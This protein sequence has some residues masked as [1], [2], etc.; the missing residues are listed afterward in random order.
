MD[1]SVKVTRKA[2][3]KLAALFSVRKE[4][5]PHLRKWE[6]RLLPD[7]YDHN[8]FEYTGQPTAEEF[9]RALAYQ[10]ENNCGFIKLEGN[11]PLQDSFG[12]EAGV[13]LTMVLKGDSSRWRRNR[14]AVFGTP[15]LAELEEL[16][17]KHFGSLYGEDFT[18]RNAR[19]LYEKLDYHGAYLGE[20]LAGACYSF[21]ADNTVCVDGLIV[22]ES[23]RHQY[24]ATSLLAHIAE[25]AGSLLFLHADADDTPKD[26]YAKMG[27][28]VTDRLYEYSCTDLQKLLRETAQA[29]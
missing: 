22:D 10:R 27:F 18:R 12:L 24:I 4:F 28:A 8:C 13:T 3:E 7:K 14:E 29:R 23:C 15:S 5:S 26:M 20:K 1:D 2:E 25:E 9:A 21:S 11:F 16:E 17:V 19:R 6:D